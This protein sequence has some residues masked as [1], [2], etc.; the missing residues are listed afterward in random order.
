[1]RFNALIIAPP[2]A[3]GQRADLCV[4]ADHS[5]LDP[6]LGIGDAISALARLAKR[7]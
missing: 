2:F 7:V 6:R 3:P 5:R 1:M 4:T